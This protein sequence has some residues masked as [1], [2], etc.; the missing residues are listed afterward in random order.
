M[1]TAL[2]SRPSQENRSYRPSV[3]RPWVLFVAALRRVR[4]PALGVSADDC[5]A[6]S[7]AD[8]VQEILK[9]RVSPERIEDRS[10]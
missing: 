4:K 10:H 2:H 7:K 1:A 9:S 5:I 3:G 6:A 8:T